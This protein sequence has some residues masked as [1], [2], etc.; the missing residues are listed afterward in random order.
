[1]IWVE[2]LSLLEGCP[3]KR[4]AVNRGCS[5]YV[6]TEQGWWQDR[7]K[8]E[9]AKKAAAEPKKAAPSAPSPA[10]SGAGRGG[11]ARGG[12]VAGRGTAGRGAPRGSALS[13]NMVSTYL[14]YCISV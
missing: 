1:M 5:V 7:K 6:I 10:K 2:L 11:P 3:A 14:F 9:E 13:C 8:A 12:A 4:V